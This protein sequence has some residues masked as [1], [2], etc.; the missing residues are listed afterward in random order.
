MTQTSLRPARYDLARLL[1]DAER[2]ANSIRDKESKA[3]VLSGLAKALA[4]TDTDR[5]EGIANSITNERQKASALR[6]VAEALPATPPRPGSAPRRRRT[7]RP[8]DRRAPLQVTGGARRLE[9]IG[10]ARRGEST[11]THR[12]RPR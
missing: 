10:A 2:V 1:A 4:P 7:H 3:R 5:A 9:T 6:A 11:G 8:I 12:P